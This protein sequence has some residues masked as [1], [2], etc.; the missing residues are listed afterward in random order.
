MSDNKFYDDKFKP[1]EQFGTY[2]KRPPTDYTSEYDG[3]FELK[4]DR[5]YGLVAI[6]LAPRGVRGDFM[7]QHIRLY[8]HLRELK[9]FCTDSTAGGDEAFGVIWVC[10]ANLTVPQRAIEEL[11]LALIHHLP[12]QSLPLV[13]GNGVRAYNHQDKVDELDTFIKDFGKEGV[14]TKEHLKVL[15]DKVIGE[16][17]RVL[18]KKNTDQA[19]DAKTATDTD[20]TNNPDKPTE[21]DEEYI[22]LD[23]SYIHAKKPLSLAADIVMANQGQDDE[24]RASV[25]VPARGRV[26]LFCGK[27]NVGKTAW[28]FEIAGH[29]T[30]TDFKVLYIASDVYAI[31]ASPFLKGLGIIHDNFHIEST[32]KRIY[33]KEDLEETIVKFKRELGRRP[34]LIIFDSLVDFVAETSDSFMPMNSRGQSKGFDE[35]R[36]SDWKLA[37]SRLIN[38]LAD[39]YDCAIIGTVHSTSKGELNE[40]EV[41]QSYRL[42]GLVDDTFMVFDNTVRQKGAQ[43]KSLIQTLRACDSDTRLL[44]NRRVRS[45]S[46]KVHYFYDLGESVDGAS[47]GQDNVR[48]IVNLRVAVASRLPSQRK[49]LDTTSAIIDKIYEKSGGKIEVK[50]NESEV[51]RTLNCDPRAREKSATADKRFDLY[52]EAKQTDFLDLESSLKGVKVWVTQAYADHLQKIDF[53]KSQAKSRGFQDC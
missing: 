14:T 16:P 38:P 32:K 49:E 10:R 12:F 36:A 18:P 34:D 35:Y 5:N 52:Q 43:N 29:L 48:K 47:L 28:L 42:P 46:K 26:N 13:N 25:F 51:L 33:L 8:Q 19:N 4:L 50:L 17:I 45:G 21:E 37:F 20:A 27:D 44:F 6:Q 41:S 23:R 7:E 40:H 9:T 24:I 11:G 15:V 3:Y 53:Q 31:D 2:T 30:R 39:V 1:L 22:P